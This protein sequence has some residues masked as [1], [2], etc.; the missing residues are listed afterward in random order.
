MRGLNSKTPTHERQIR[1][2]AGP[3]CQVDVVVLRVLEDENVTVV[4]IDRGK[5]GRAVH[6]GTEL[7]RVASIGHHHS[8]AR[9][10]ELPSCQSAEKMLPE[11]LAYM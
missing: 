10:I 8:I 6:L 2:R 11:N 7:A 1:V 5:P 3:P 9:L 4:R